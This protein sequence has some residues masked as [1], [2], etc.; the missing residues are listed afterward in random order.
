M[1]LGVRL[2]D[3]QVAAYFH[4]SFAAVD[5]LWFMKAEEKLGFE[6]A[7][8]IDRAVWEVFP[9]IQAREL[10]RMLHAGDAADALEPVLTTALELKGFEFAVK[11][12]RP[13]FSIVITDCP[14][15]NTMVKSGRAALSARIGEAVCRTEYTA[16]ASE[17]GAKLEFSFGSPHRLCTG[18]D[19]CVLCFGN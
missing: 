18:A 16:W 13:G 14:W 2:T 10:K 1:I 19:T 15:H 6:A 5:G 9:R 4:R 11:P 7:L 8:E 17:F 3:E 12:G